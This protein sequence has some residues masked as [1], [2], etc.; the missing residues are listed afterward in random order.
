MLGSVD[1]GVADDGECTGHK[2]AAQIAI[3][4]LADTAEMLGPAG[5]LWLPFLSN[6]GIG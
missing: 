4:L 1:L 2:Q 6:R 5:W 3:T